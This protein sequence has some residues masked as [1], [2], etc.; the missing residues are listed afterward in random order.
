[1][2]KRLIARI[3]GWSILTMAISAGFVFGYALPEFSAPKA[4]GTFQALIDDRRNLYFALLGGLILIQILDVIVSYAFY[5][6]FVHV[7]R[8]IAAIAGG[9]RF[10]YTL[11]FSLGTCF[12]LRNLTSDTAS[13][14]WILSN[15]QSFQNIWT[16]GLIIFGIHIFLLGY[17]MKLH[18]RIHFIL[19]ILALIAGCSYSLVSTLQLMDFDPEFT[20]SLE[21]ILALPMTVGELALAVWMIAKG[22]KHE[23]QIT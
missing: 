17:L 6:F 20:G 12:L 15:F 18:K 14:E 21:I 2:N 1:M 10:V 22:G 4:G 11:I 9:L 7:H 8:K 23:I 3:S 13:D 16:F 19:W 5:K